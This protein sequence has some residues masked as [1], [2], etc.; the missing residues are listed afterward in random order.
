MTAREALNY[1]RGAMMQIYDISLP[2][3]P[4]LAPWPGDTPYSFTWNCTKAEGVAVNLGSIS[5]SLHVGTH[6]DAPYHFDSF[7]ASIDQLSL[8]PYVGDAIVLD[9]SGK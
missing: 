6:A 5:T 2:I 3:D 9:L 7:G 4:A 1:V 8:G